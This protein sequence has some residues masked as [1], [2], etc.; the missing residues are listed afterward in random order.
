[1]N[2]LVI[3]VGGSNV[4]M[5]ATGQTKQR[6]FSS[7]KRLTPQRMVQK[8]QELTTDWDYEVVSLGIP[9]LVGHDGVRA[10]PANLGSG[11]VGFDFASA[12]GR[13]VKVVNDAAMQ[14]LGSYQ[15]GRMLFLG[16]GTS[17][18]SAFISDQVLVPLELGRLPWGKDTLGAV[19]GDQGRQQR[20]KRAWQRAVEE[21]V[22]ALKNAFVAD[23]VVLGG[24][25][26]KT[27]KPLPEAA[28]RGGN[29]NAFEGGFLLWEEVV[30]PLDEHPAAHLVWK[31][32]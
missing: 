14:A 7:G 27:V 6:K 21:T 9:A 30:T 18:G 26:T 11:W 32:V 25:S 8:V 1:M 24:G 10:E 28:R 16:L 29:Q 12:F 17:L 13:P 4:K 15:G 5:L 22:R 31:M 19:L 20:G 23:Y 2:I 3:D